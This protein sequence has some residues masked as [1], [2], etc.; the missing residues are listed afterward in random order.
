[1]LGNLQVVFV[2][3]LAWLILGERPSNRVA[4]RDPGRPVGVLLISGVFE[5]GAYG[6]N[7]GLGVR[8]GS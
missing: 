1:M 6:N 4:G 5:S 2:G 7:P 8:T 3:L